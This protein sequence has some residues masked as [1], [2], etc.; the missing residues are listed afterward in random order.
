MG[1]C[2]LDRR[3]AAISAPVTRI[4]AYSV[5]GSVDV[6]VPFGVEV[7]LEG[8]AIMGSKDAKLTGPP[9]LPGAPVVRVN[10]FTAMGSVTVR[11]R[12]SLGERLSQAIKDRLTGGGPPQPSSP[13]P[14][15][16]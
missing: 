4:N 16:R 12:P 1:S 3:G 5:M 2:K 8:I 11:D 13:P 9:P 6:I 15:P 10:A 14:P 7:E